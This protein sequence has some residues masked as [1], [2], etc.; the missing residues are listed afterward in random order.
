MP[1]FAGELEERNGEQEYTYYH[2]IEADTLEEARKLYESYA[3]TFYP[4]DEDDELPEYEN[5][6][7]CHL[8]GAI[9]VRVDRLE[10]TTKEQWMEEQFNLNLLKGG[11]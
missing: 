9:F 5:D 8:D 4:V 11:E 7:Y 6:G 3:Q 2:I 10:P 1:Y